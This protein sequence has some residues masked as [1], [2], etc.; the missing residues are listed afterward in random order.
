MTAKWHWLAGEA[1]K[2]LNRS[3][4]IESAG[5]K[6]GPVSLGHRNP[7]VKEGSVVLVIRNFA[8]ALITPMPRAPYI[9]EKYTRRSCTPA[10][11][12]ATTSSAIRY[13][14]EVESWADIQSYNIEFVMKR[15]RE[16]KMP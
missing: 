10:R 2:L 1:A 12:P 11:L 6:A 5:S 8:C 16:P 13:E 4:Q 9:R 14:T 7:P 15:L 3:E